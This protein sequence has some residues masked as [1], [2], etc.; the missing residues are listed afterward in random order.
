M[1]RHLLL[2]T[3][4]TFIP[5]PIPPPQHNTPR[6][7]GIIIQK[8]CQEVSLLCVKPPFSHVN[9]ARMTMARQL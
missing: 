8:G 6:I 7:S 2:N 3:L 4:Y 1:S 5:L 9:S